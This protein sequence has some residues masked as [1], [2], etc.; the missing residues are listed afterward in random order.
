MFNTGTNDYKQTPAIVIEYLPGKIFLAKIKN[1][2][3]SQ[4]S[5]ILHR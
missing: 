3:E 5:L 1:I 4:R 2:D